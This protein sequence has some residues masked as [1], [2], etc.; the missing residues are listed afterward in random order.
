MGL[1]QPHGGMCEPHMA[2][3]CS[4]VLP[5]NTYSPA[6]QHP[7]LDAIQML[8]G[9]EIIAVLQPACQFL[10]ISPIGSML[11]VTCVPG[12]MSF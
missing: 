9:I 7:D 10:S 1:A 6:V 8:Y 12:I 5:I 11:Q 3:L 2:Y 4:A